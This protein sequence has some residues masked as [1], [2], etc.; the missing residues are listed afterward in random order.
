MAKADVSASTLLAWDKYKG[1]QADQALQAIYEHAG[2]TCTTLCGWYWSSIRTKRRTSLVVRFLTFVLLILGTV[3]PILAALNGAPGD[4]LKF[5]QYGVVALALGGLL[6]VADRVFGWSSGWLRYITTVTAMENL[7]RKFELEWA[8]Y[9]LNKAGAL[10]E[11]DCKQLFDLAKRFEDDVVKLQID[12]TDKWATEFSSG[13]ALLGDLIKA[14]RE[15]GEKAVEAARAVVASQQAGAQAS[16]KAQQNGA[17]EVALVHEADPIPVTIGIDDN[18]LEEFL[19][20]AWSK[21]DLPPGQHILNIVTK[22]TTPQTIKK[23]VEIPPGGLA[24]VE[25]KMA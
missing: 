10:D 20:T 23:I 7:T 3:L 6:Q 1:K 15:S 8:G 14:Q 2:G 24:H 18:P 16:E 9:I 25:V 22:G 21:L 13:T 19:G 5:T 12:E 17:V 11:S 4:K